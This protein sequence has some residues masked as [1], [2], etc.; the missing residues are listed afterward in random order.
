VIAVPIAISA[1]WLTF[2]NRALQ[3]TVG[4]IAIAIGLNT[5]VS[6]T[7]AQLQLSGVNA[8]LAQ[9]SAINPGRRVRR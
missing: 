5:I 9:S 2:A 3:G 7:L 6:T 1:R 8:S 4:F